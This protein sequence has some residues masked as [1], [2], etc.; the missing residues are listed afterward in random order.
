MKRALNRQILRFSPKKYQELVRK[1]KTAVKLFTPSEFRHNV[2]HSLAM[3]GASAAEIAFVLGHSSHVVAKHYI[4]ATPELAR[5]RYRALGINATWQNMM[6]LMVTGDLVYA[7]NWDGIKVAGI[8]GSQLHT[9]CGGCGRVSKECP[10]AE[11]RACYGCL[12]FRPFIE[13]EHEQVLLGVQKEITEA[14]ALSNAVGDARN[15]TVEILIRIKEN[16]MFVMKRV[17]NRPPRPAQSVDAVA[18]SNELPATSPDTI[19]KSKKG[20]LL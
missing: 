14:I 3:Q 4:L 7:E 12:Y 15:P 17:E 11:L 9:N 13:G 6:A 18:S 1:D 2:G 10:F 19:T 5:V 8:V 16:I 20:K